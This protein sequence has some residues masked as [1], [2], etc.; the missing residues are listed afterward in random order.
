MARGIPG[1]ISIG[2]TEIEMVEP[3]CLGNVVRTIF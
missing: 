2:P 1:P 3:F